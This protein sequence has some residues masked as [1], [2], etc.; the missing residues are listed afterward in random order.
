M[1]KGTI[2]AL[3]CISLIGSSIVIIPTKAVAKTN[4]SYNVSLPTKDTFI[5]TKEDFKIFSNSVDALT[6]ETNLNIKFSK[7]EFNSTL[8]I[9]D[10]NREIFR[11]KILP[12]T[13]ELNLPI[14]LNSYGNHNIKAFIGICAPNFDAYSMSNEIDLGF[15]NPKIEKS[16]NLQYNYSNNQF[17]AKLPTAEYNCQLYVYDNG[18]LSYKTKL[19]RP[20]DNISFSLP[21]ETYGKHEITAYLGIV[22]GSYDYNPILASNTTTFYK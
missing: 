17:T 15:F 7:E 22:A 6:G 12:N 5:N 10:N 3:L 18:V 4:T 19:N 16:I 21:S 1:K 2:V 9:L 20:T 11:S 14:K 8:I 13:S